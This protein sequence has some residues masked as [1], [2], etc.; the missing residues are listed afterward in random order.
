[1]LLWKLMCRQHIVCVNA[2]IAYPDQENDAYLTKDSVDFHTHLGYTM[3]GEFHQCAYKFDR[4]YNM[5]WMEKSLCERPQNP[6]PMIWFS[7][8]RKKDAKPESSGSE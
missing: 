7:K 8:L 3:V 5:V 2:C 1:M 4:W 6:E